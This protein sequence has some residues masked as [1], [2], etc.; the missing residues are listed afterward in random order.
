MLYELLE[1]VWRPW[2]TPGSVQASHPP[3]DTT[4]PKFVIDVRGCQCSGVQ[5]S[6]WR[7]PGRFGQLFA[8]SW[9]SP[10]AP[11]RRTRNATNQ[12]KPISENVGQ[13]GGTN[14]C[15]AQAQKFPGS[16]SRFPSPKNTLKNLVLIARTRVPK[17]NFPRGPKTSRK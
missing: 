17:Q 10:G 16:S 8:C 5:G 7:L 9:S 14:P 12:N 6:L 13:P 4:A 3:S 15:R 1:S 2:G 11:F